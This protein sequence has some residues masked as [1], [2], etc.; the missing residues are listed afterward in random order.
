[1]PTKQLSNR[2]KITHGHT[3]ASTTIGSNLSAGEWSLPSILGEMSTLQIPPC[4]HVFTSSQFAMTNS[5]STPIFESTLCPTHYAGAQQRKMLYSGQ[6]WIRNPV[7]TSP[8]VCY[9]DN[10]VELMPEEMIREYT[11]FRMKVL[12][13]FQGCPCRRCYAM[14]RKG[15]S[16]TGCSPPRINTMGTAAF[17]ASYYLASTTSTSQLTNSEMREPRGSLLSRLK[18]DFTGQDYKM[19]KKRLR[20]AQKGTSI[21]EPEDEVVES[22]K[23]RRAKKIKI[24][25]EIRA[26]AQKLE[27]IERTKRHKEELERQTKSMEELF[28]ELGEG[29]KELK[30][31]KF[32]TSWFSNEKELQMKLIHEAKAYRSIMGPKPLQSS[33]ISHTQRSKSRVGKAELN[34]SAESFKK[35]RKARKKKD[36]AGDDMISDHKDPHEGDVEGEPQGDGP[37]YSKDK[38]GPSLGIINTSKSTKSWGQKEHHYKGRT[39]GKKTRRMSHEHGHKIGQKAPMWSPKGTGGGDVDDETHIDEQSEDEDEGE[40]HEEGVF[41]TQHR[42]EDIHHRDEG[43]RDK[44]RRR[45]KKEKKTKLAVERGRGEKSDEIGRQAEEGK[46]DEIGPLAQEGKGGEKVSDKYLRTESPASTQDGEQHEQEITGSHPRQE[47]GTTMLVPCPTALEI[48]PLTTTAEEDEEEE[49]AR[50]RRVE[51]DIYMHHRRFS[52]VPVIGR[53]RLHIKDLLD[54]NDEGSMFEFGNKKRKDV[55]PMKAVTEEGEKGGKDGDDRNETKTNALVHGGESKNNKGT[56][57]DLVFS[58]DSAGST[59]SSDSAYDSGSESYGGSEDEESD[60]EAYGD[61]ESGSNGGSNENG[62][63]Y[64]RHTPPEEDGWG[65]DASCDSR[66]TDATEKGSGTSSKMKEGRT[67]EKKKE[68]QRRKSHYIDGSEG[69]TEDNEGGI[70]DS[71]EESGSG[72]SETNKKMVPSHAALKGTQRKKEK[73]RIRWD[74]EMSVD[75]SIYVQEWRKRMR[76]KSKIIRQEWKTGVRTRKPDKDKKDDQKKLGSS[77]A[78]FH[79]NKAVAATRASQRITN[80]MGFDSTASAMMCKCASLVSDEPWPSDR[81]CY[82]SSESLRELNTLHIL[83]EKNAEAEARDGLPLSPWLL[84]K[85]RTEAMGYWKSGDLHTIFAT[86]RD[87]LASKGGWTK[88]NLF[89]LLEPVFLKKNMQDDGVF[90]TEKLLHQ[91]VTQVFDVREAEQILKYG[92]VEVLLMPALGSALE[93]ISR[94]ANTL[95]KKN[96]TYQG[97]LEDLL[98]TCRDR[99]ND[100]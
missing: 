93:E 16:G 21:S 60:G 71:E 86:N 76:R 22:K 78:D 81:K 47:D 23:I 63:N 33:E 38:D 96:I 73:K 25:N 79:W 77:M 17:N 97:F 37:V 56:I 11:G 9:K 2:P 83:R 57:K 42:G 61:E 100:S 31:D 19:V 54:D 69:V 91:R 20:L 89:T 67:M 84:K 53:N 94:L 26:K 6:S 55:H 92:A 7:T 50:I 59:S 40:E 28:T 13:K 87:S 66:G 72:S 35:E 4:D 88:D 51:D 12:H 44:S 10:R 5:F 1:M 27:R 58:S 14:R 80:M 64:S 49:L 46:S 85:R 32:F 98:K 65:H 74:E 45:K 68:G 18:D 90:Q 24:R 15:A 41:L 34:W 3:L 95:S 99:N 70:E 43:K 39:H 52:F 8:F 29:K 75:D 82:A 30:D 62:S 36:D 48:V